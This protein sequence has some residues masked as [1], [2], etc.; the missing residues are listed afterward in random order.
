MLLSSSDTRRTL[1]HLFLFTNSAQ[2]RTGFNSPI[3]FKL[4]LLYKFNAQLFCTN[5]LCLHFLAKEIGK[6]AVWLVILSRGVKILH[7]IS[8][9]SKYFLPEFGDFFVLKICPTF[10]ICAL[11]QHEP[12]SKQI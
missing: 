5:S 2:K 11:C 9:S 10:V 4:L 12:K 8:L 7:S 3:F 1:M 6:K